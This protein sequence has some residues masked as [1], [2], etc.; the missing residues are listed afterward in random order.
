MSIKL[1]NYY[2]DFVAG[3]EQQYIDAYNC[4]QIGNYQKIAEKLHA[5]SSGINSIS[6]DDSWSDSAKSEFEQVK[7]NISNAIDDLLNKV[8]NVGVTID[9]LY[10]A[11]WEQ[12]KLLKKEYERASIVYRYMPQRNQYKKRDENGD[13]VTD[14]VAYQNAYNLWEDKIAAFNLNM[15]EMYNKACSFKNE[16]GYRNKSV[17]EEFSNYS[18]DFNLVKGIDFEKSEIEY[19]KDGYSILSDVG[20]E[21]YKNKHEDLAKVNELPDINVA[22]REIEVNGVPLNVY[23]VFSGEENEESINMYFDEFE[24]SI[25]PGLHRL[26]PEYVSL[27]VGSGLDYTLFDGN[28][29]SHNTF[30]HSE[31]EDDYTSFTY[32]NNNKVYFGINSETV[33]DDVYF[34]D[35]QVKVFYSP[36]IEQYVETMDPND[37]MAVSNE[38]NKINNPDYALNSSTPNSTSKH[39][40][41]RFVAEFVMPELYGE[42]Y[43]NN[44]DYTPL[45]GYYEDILL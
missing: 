9:E 45:D 3:Q 20:V 32:E 41:K 39:M 8:S 34:Y 31:N 43:E 27:A 16:L 22:V 6:C 17:D 1:H 5:V 37:S 12:A 2:E 44:F 28:F 38:I 26:N 10:V 35:N 40:T 21:N 15:A 19:A 23:Y 7:K 4:A 33:Q 25:V 18:I 14:N 30:L 42:D 11:M 24:K 36:I 13:F 29:I